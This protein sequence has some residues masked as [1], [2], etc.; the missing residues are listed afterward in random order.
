[1]SNRSLTGYDN[2]DAVSGKPDE[3]AFLYRASAEG[4]GRLVCASCRPSG[5]RPTGVEVGDV[6]S[7]SG[8]IITHGD[9][10]SSS[11]WLAASVPG[12]EPSVHE[13][14]LYQPR[15]LSD[16]GRVFF[17]SADALV[18]QDVNHNQDVYE[19]ESAGVGGCT[20]E[21]SAYTVV[22]DGCV[23]LISSGKAVGESV[24]MDASESGNDVFFMNG[25]KLTGND[26][27]NALDMY[28]AHLCTDGSPC[29]SEAPSPPACTT[30][31]ACR[32]APEPQPAI[33]GV[34]ASATFSGAGN[35]TPSGPVPVVKPKP[36]T[37]AQKLTRAL[38]ACHKNKN[39]HK[40]VVCE[41]QAHKQYGAKQARTGK[42]VKKGKG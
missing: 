42:A 8:L 11:A 38:N 12:Y 36:L 7:K 40:R 29:A 3:E 22:T 25:E 4:A 31:D 33:F 27:D 20:T 26:I 39:K 19:F 6:I 9:G 18:A 35:L 14:S 21:S 34:P 17:D 41:R 10:W 16:E 37:R 28:D 1:M 30:A 24:F 15:Y 2:H 13:E 5:A 23:G 32:A